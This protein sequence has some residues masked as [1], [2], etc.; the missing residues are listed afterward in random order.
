VSRRFAQILALS[1]IALSSL[2]QRR[3]SAAVIILGVAGVVAL[4]TSVMAVSLSLVRAISGTGQPDRAIVIQRGSSSETG[5]FLDLDS[6]E[7]IQSFA[8]IRRA[9]NG[10]PSSSAEILTRIRRVESDTGRAGDVVVRG[11]SP[12][13]LALRPEMSIVQGRMLHPAVFEMIV[14]QSATT[15]FRGLQ[16]HQHVRFRNTDWLIVGVFTS[17]GDAHEMEVMTDSNT[18]LS[19]TY[20]NGVNS[21]SVRLQ[22]PSVFEAFQNA[23]SRDPSLVV[24]AY[25]ESDYYRQQSEPLHKAWS[26]VAYVASGIMALGAMFAAANTMYSAISSRTK[27]IG[28]L[29]AIGFGPGAVFASV[30]IES[31]FLA[32]LGALVGVAIVY[33][34][35]GGATFSTRFGAQHVAARVDINLALVLVGIAWAC[36][37]SVIGGLFPA[38]SAARQPIV[39][40][41]GDP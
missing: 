25:R 27:E 33:L 1:G 9:P 26:F 17:G 10:Q 29:R 37:I 14:G 41:L 23:I 31:L 28:T 4:L 18:L 8:G 3:A 7:K 35:V 38:M 15:R 39:Q 11:V 36:S 24:T 32:L 12:N 30:L 20:G 2:P 16:L 6:A 34:V 5:S 40:A 22:D 19:V 21:V 13:V